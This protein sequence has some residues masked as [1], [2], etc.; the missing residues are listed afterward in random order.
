MQKKTKK[1]IL[2]TII[3]SVSYSLF[4]QKKIVFENHNY[5]IE[6]YHCGTNCHY[7]NIYN[8]NTNKTVKLW[9]VYVLDTVNYFAVCP[10]KE[11][12]L[13]IFSFTGKLIKTI[14]LNTDKDI[15]CWYLWDKM[16][17]ENG[18]LVIHWNEFVNPKKFTPN[19]KTKHKILE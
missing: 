2:T 5:K 3:L 8:K 10:S 1:I 9:D 12:N 16:Y 19:T 18:Y 15:F 13:N 14:Y 17:F 6:R 4:A 11:N 7:D